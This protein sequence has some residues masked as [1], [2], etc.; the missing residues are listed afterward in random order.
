MNVL[1]LDVDGVLNSYSFYNSLS[2]EEKRTIPIDNSCLARVKRIVD[3]S[4]ALIVLTSSWRGGWDPDPARMELEGRILTD[5]FDKHGLSIYSKTPDTYPGNRAME[6]IQWM[7]DQ[8]KKIHKYVIL[9]DV[10]YNW[11]DY[12][13]ARHWVPT[14]YYQ[15]GLTDTETEKAIELFGK[16]SFYF[17]RERFSRA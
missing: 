17:F 12:H 11:S 7:K 1:F 10:D 8:A 4:G 13:M 3:A 15:G 14:D 2:P 6:I 9:D 16:S 5:L